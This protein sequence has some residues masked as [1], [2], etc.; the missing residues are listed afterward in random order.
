MEMHRPHILICGKKRAGKTTLIDRIIRETTLPVYGYK[1]QM[2]RDAGDEYGHVFIVPA[3]EDVVGGTCNINRAD[4]FSE[5]DRTG[6]V[7]GTGNSNRINQNDRTGRAIAVGK[8]GSMNRCSRGNVTGRTGGNEVGIAGGRVIRVNPDVFNSIGCALVKGVGKDGD[9][10]IVMDEIG[11]MEDEAEDFCAAVREAFDGDIPVLA[12][13]KRTE[14]ASRHIDTILHHP[15]TNVFMLTKSNREEV[16]AK[17][18][19]IV[20][21]W[22]RNCDRSCDRN[23][24]RNRARRGGAREV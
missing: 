13:I 22:E 24:D 7:S 11:Y 8:T 2:V 6:S 17:V 15:R 10:M 19:E 20:R 5:N 18:S 21:E 14:H 3:G 12:S 1:T 16:Y 4:R 23:S 9:G